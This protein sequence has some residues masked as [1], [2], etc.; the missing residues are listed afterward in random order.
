MFIGEDEVHEWLQYAGP[1]AVLCYFQGFLG[2]GLGSNGQPLP[3]ADRRRLVRVASR[4]WQAADRKVL[5]LAQKRLGP[6]S[7]AYLA[8]RR[9][10]PEQDQPNVCSRHAEVLHV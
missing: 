4:L 1:G 3:V 7:W 10:L 6:M 2:A 9:P 5:H 8:V